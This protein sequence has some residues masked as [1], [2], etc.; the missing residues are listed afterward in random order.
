LPQWTGFERV[1]LDRFDAT[2][3]TTTWEPIYERAAWQAFLE[4]HGYRPFTPATFV[5]A[6]AR[7]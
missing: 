3:I 2:R 5:K 1:L 7:P 6:A 4:G